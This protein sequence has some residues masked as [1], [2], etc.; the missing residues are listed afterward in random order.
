MQRARMR[1]LRL[2]RTGSVKSLA[3]WRVH[4]C[5]RLR[6]R[7]C[8]GKPVAPFHE[9]RVQHRQ[10]LLG[11]AERGAWLCA[12]RVDYGQRVRLGEHFRR[13]R[14]SFRTRQDFRP[15][16]QR[17]TVLQE[18]R[19]RLE[20][21]TRA[22]VLRQRPRHALAHRCESGARHPQR[23]GHCGV[24]HVLCCRQG[25]PVC[26]G[27]VLEGRGD[28]ASRVGLSGRRLATDPRAGPCSASHSTGDAQ[29]RP[30][31]G[32]ACATST[33][34]SCSTDCKWRTS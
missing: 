31:S 14:D 3:R 33:R 25:P 20:R 7:L 22:R 13:E 6:R 16:F 10:R 28:I 15:L 29:T 1:A 12:R 21:G 11:G 26:P 19:A 23:L 9:L 2:P 5:D 8:H 32:R 24:R 4:R 34:S 18:L 30:H 17:A 27:R